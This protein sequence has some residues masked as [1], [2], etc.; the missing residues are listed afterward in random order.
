M[1]DSLIIKN[2][3]FEAIDMLV[4]QNKLKGLKTFADIYE[5]NSSN[6]FQ[7]KAYGNR[8]VKVEWLFYLSRDFNISEKWLISGKGNMFK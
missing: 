6:L 5:L 8:N 2:R 3:F 1:N 4:Q 7:I